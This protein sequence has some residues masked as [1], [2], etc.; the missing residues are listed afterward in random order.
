MNFT[1][2]LYTQPMP[3]EGEGEKARRGDQRNGTEWADT[4][5]DTDM[6]AL[7]AP[8]SH[9][10]IYMDVYSLTPHVVWPVCLMRRRK[11]PLL[12]GNSGL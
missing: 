12:G 8:C 4:H 6:P 2:A 7:C 1:G 9:I 3:S 10:I 11:R 5:T